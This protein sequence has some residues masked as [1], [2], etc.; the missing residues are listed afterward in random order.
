MPMINGI[1][2]GI[3]LSEMKE[4]LKTIVNIHN[5]YFQDVQLASK[6]NLMFANGAYSEMEEHDSEENKEKYS[7]YKEKELSSFHLIEFMQTLQD[8]QNKWY[9]TYINDIAEKDS[10]DDGSLVIEAD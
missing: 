5:K 7:E 3:S 6:V 1:Y 8:V 9:Q 10:D 4:D 2:K